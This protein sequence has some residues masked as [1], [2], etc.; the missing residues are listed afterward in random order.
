MRG[1]RGVIAGSEGRFGSGG[2]FTR[3]SSRWIRSLIE[4]SRVQCLLGGKLGWFGSDGVFGRTGGCGIESELS[5]FGRV[6][7][8]GW[9]CLSYD[10]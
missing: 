2:K 5:N 7:G 3:I 1:L 6:S 8:L 4:L 9:P 10:D